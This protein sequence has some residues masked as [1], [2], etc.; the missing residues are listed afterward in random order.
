MSISKRIRYFNKRFTNRLFIHFAGKKNSPFA[1]LQHVGRKSGKVF[2]IPIMVVPDKKGF[3]IALTYGTE[4]DWYLNITA[5]KSGELRWNGKPY[6]FQ[7][8]QKL[9]AKEGQKAFGKLK[10]AVLKKLNVEDFIFIR[11]EMIV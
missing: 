10:G 4:V 8:I 7:D 2:K 9:Q 6:H 1:L 5:A 3:V 11:A